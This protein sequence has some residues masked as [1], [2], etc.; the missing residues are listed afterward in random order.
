[1]RSIGAIALEWEVQVGDVILSPSRANIYT[2]LGEL[3]G[4]PEDGVSRI[5]I[6]HTSFY[7]RIYMHEVPRGRNPNYPLVLDGTYAGWGWDEGVKSD[8]SRG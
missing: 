3:P 1:M 8:P 2:V 6:L 5:L 7:G 4:I